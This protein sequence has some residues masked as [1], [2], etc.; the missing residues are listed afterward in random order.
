M[1]RIDLIYNGTAYTV[2]NRSLDEFRAEVEAALASP[3][4]QWLTVNYGEGRANPALLLITPYTPLSIITNGFD[5]LN[6]EHE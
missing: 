1:K 5:E 6:A 3:T 2:N 4:P